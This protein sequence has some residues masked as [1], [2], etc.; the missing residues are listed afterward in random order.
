MPKYINKKQLAKVNQL[1]IDPL[2]HKASKARA[3]NLRFIL[4]CERYNKA[5]VRVANLKPLSIDILSNKQR[6]Q[7]EEKFKQPPR[8]E[9]QSCN[10]QIIFKHQNRADICKKRI[11]YLGRKQILPTDNKVKLKLEKFVSCKKC[12]FF[13]A[14]KAYRG[15]CRIYLEKYLNECFFRV[16]GIR[17]QLFDGIYRATLS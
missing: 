2:N 9:I 10:S 8:N 5:K 3:K 16:V 6:P 4:N 15:F 12:C 17:H 13:D 7:Q 11:R 1:D 14:I